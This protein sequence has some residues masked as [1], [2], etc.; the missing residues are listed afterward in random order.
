VIEERR[1]SDLTLV[2]RLV[3]QAKPYWL[4]VLGVFVLSFASAPLALLAPVGIKIAVDSVLSDKPLPGF[5][6]GPLPQAW[7]ESPDTLLLVAAALIVGVAVLEQIVGIANTMLSTYTGERLLLDFRTRLFRHVQKLSL[8][9]H[10]GRGSADTLYRIQYDAF[11]VQNILL[12]ALAPLLTSVVT[13]VAMLYVIALIDWQLAIFALLVAP[14][15]IAVSHSYRRR[16]RTQSREVKQ[17]ESGALSVVQE[18]LGAVRVVKAFSG[19]DREEERFTRTSAHGMRARLRL[20]LSSGH[21]GGLIGILTALGTAGVLYIGVRHVRSG[22]LTLGDL[23]LVMAYLTQLYSPIKTVASKAGRMQ[24][25]LA[26]AERA[27]ALLDEVPE[28]EDR[29]DARPLSRARGEVGFDRASFS[30]DGRQPAIRDVSFAVPAGARVGIA[31]R[32]GA[33]KTTLVSLL[34]RFYDP[35]EGRVLLDGVDLR[36]YRLADLRR[37]FS[38][39]LQEPL[40]FSTTIGENIAYARP[41]ATHEEIVAAARAANAH[42]FITALPEGYDTA[43]GDRGLRLSGGERQRVSLAR[44]FLRD[45][46]VLILDE[47]TSSVDVA[48]EAVIMEATERLMAGRTTFMIAHRLSTLESCDVRIEIDAGRVASVTERMPSSRRFARLPARL[49]GRT[50]A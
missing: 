17:L 37:Q 13:I 2:R 18:V 29:P 1:Y 16:L 19:E 32:T 40:L 5:I 34:A 48:T 46:P 39:V 7:T 21:F 30:Y 4:H 43:V 45:A 27:F 11:A 22:V 14:L 31:G 3:A 35:T 49:A 26:S 20:A 15:L 38:I 25:H 28:V 33:G 8:A 12:G 47:P 44:A 24:A 6:D 9:F 42:E 10:D 23:L 41:D 50:R 36:D